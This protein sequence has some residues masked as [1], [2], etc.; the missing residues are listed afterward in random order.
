MLHVRTTN[1]T[2]YMPTAHSPR[3]APQGPLIAVGPDIRDGRVRVATALLEAI[4]RAGGV[5]VVLG[6][7]PSSAVRVLDECSGLVLSGGDDPRMEAFGVPTHAKSV[8]V[9][10]QRQALDLA[11]LQ[12]AQQ[13]AELPVLG[14]CLGMQY[15]GLVAG[16]ALE[17]HLPDVLA[18][19]PDH[20]DN[21]VHAVHGQ[22]GQG[23]VVSHHRQALT[24]AGSFD[25][26]ARAP[27]GVIEAIGDPDREWVMGVQWHPERMGQG[28]LG[29]GLFE[30]LLCA[31]AVVS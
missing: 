24:H 23:S 1:R 26:V 5:P 21:A 19:A 4:D 30:Q 7:T 15:M 31:A 17:Q 25:I 22:L 12:A 11:L 14:I 28:P 29:D 9:H 13:R 8:V 16:G 10:P 6:H 20:A 2:V 18:T 27:D 3:P